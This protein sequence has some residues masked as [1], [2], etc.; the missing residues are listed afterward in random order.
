[1]VLNNKEKQSISTSYQQCFRS[2]HQEL[3]Q[4]RFAKIVLSRTE[5]VALT[6]AV[7]AEQLFWRA[8]QR[9][10][11]SFI[12]LVC[13]RKAGTWLMATPEVL[14]QNDT[15]RF[16][17]YLMK[18]QS[19]IDS[20]QRNATVLESIT[21]ANDRIERSASIKRE[22]VAILQESEKLEATAKLISLREG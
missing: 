19:M 15:Q 14:V 9:Y 13:T 6:R 4:A 21:N 2:F 3:V 7:D 17:E 10:P 5:D 12:A 16:Q 1:M 18:L 22:C 11:R 8:C 20:L